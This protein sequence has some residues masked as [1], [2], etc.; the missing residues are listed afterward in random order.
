MLFFNQKSLFMTSITDPSNHEPPVWRRALLI[1]GVVAIA[2][3]AF[4]LTV[5]HLER[6]ADRDQAEI[7][8]RR[9]VISLTNSYAK[10]LQN[11]IEKI[12]QLSLIIASAGKIGGTNQIFENLPSYGWFNPLLIDQHGIVRGSHAP[13]TIGMSL[14]DARFFQNHFQSTS[15]ELKINPLEPGIGKLAGK[16]VARFSRRINDAQGQFAGVISLSMLPEQLTKIGNIVVLDNG[17]TMAIKFTNGDTLSRHDIGREFSQ[18]DFDL[19]SRTDTAKNFSEIRV[20]GNLMY[21]GWAKLDNYP[22]EAVIAISHSNILRSFN[23]TRDLYNLLQAAGSSLIIFLCLTGGW[24]QSRRD[25]RL[26]HEKKITN[27]FR[28]A[29]DESREELYM[30]SP[31]LDKDGVMTDFLVE[32]CNGQAMRMTGKEKGDLIGK[33]L[34]EI[35]VGENLSATQLFL[36]TAMSDGFAEKEVFIYREGPKKK[37]WYQ[38]RAVRADLG[39]AVTL[40]DITE[41]KEKENQLKQLALTDALTHLPNRHWMKQQLPFMMEA[42]EKNSYQFAAL[43]IDLDNFKAI[44]D[45]LGHKAGDAYLQAAARIL[46][47]SV[48]KHDH[49]LRLGGDEFMI[50]LNALDSPEVAIDIAEH[51]LIKLRDVDTLDVDSSLSPRA[52]IGVAFYPEN[53]TTPESL[54]QAA[55]I[56]MY[57]AKRSGKDRVARYSSEMLDQLSER[58]SM[59]SALRQAIP[60]GQLLLYLQPRAGAATGE[61]VG[62]EA[63]VRWQHPELGLVSPQRFIP[64]AEESHLIVEVG[65]WVAATT[66][67]TLARWRSVGKKIV[68]VSINVSTRQ[69]KEPEFRIKLH[70]QMQKHGI[71]ASEIAIELTES[72][73]IGDND[74]IRNELRLLADMGLKLMIDDFG[75]GYS[76]LARLQSLSVDVL[77]IDQSFVR[78]LSA[79]GEGI[80]LCQAMTQLG[81]TL[82]LTVVAEGVETI[83]QLQILQLMGCDEIQGF[84]AS[85][86]VP[87]DT[88]VKMLG[89]PPFFAPLG[90]I[91]SVQVSGRSL[92]T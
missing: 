65:N 70:A 4:L 84:I 21:V 68:P 49:V 1:W 46:Q 78:N 87:A 89:G 31:F 92:R 64:L 27:T 28:L 3:I 34:S 13:A 82:G 59:E 23:E 67:E 91:G 74:A 5:G 43:F 61:L 83:E 10:E 55:D 90:K 54:V 42:A 50:L 8:G 11:S 58:M 39:L 15:T 45:T 25:A 20:P 32:D 86:P 2:S 88:A 85:P 51:V 77:K 71:N 19:L 29:V 63:L 24:L 16:K 26:R 75:T 33:R 40:R 17:D 69:L 6:A 38:A 30:F 36:H 80:V 9:R 18:D 53:A 79:G 57:E 76:S 60:G 44:N 56:A 66:C 35:S 47:Q 12:D 14:S 41:V 37:Y 72:M 7:E 22:L 73:M 81:K 62:F 52:S 48:R